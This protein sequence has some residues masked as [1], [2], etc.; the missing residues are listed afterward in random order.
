M[1]TILFEDITYVYYIN[2]DIIIKCIQ[3]GTNIQSLKVEI[4]EGGS[5]NVRRPEI[6]NEYVEVGTGEPFGYC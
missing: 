2:V 5:V 4:E 1:L 3:E 6:I